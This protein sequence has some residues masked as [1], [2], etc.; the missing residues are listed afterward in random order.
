VPA[1]TVK[2]SETLLIGDN[3]AVEIITCREQPP[4]V[5]FHFSIPADMVV[6]RSKR[7]GV[8]RR[9]LPSLDKASAQDIK[10]AS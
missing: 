3:M 9:I 6:R 5:T 8:P 1:I 7:G 2:A 10:F 4:S